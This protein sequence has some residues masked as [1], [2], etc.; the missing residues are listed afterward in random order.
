MGQLNRSNDVQTKPDQAASLFGPS[1]RP[2]AFWSRLVSTSWYQ[3]NLHKCARR[4][5]RR[6]NSPPQWLDDLKHDAMLLL[7]R[8]LAHAHDGSTAASHT[9]SRACLFAA[10]LGHCREALK[11][12]RWA[13]RHAR[14]FHDE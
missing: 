13:N 10:T 1:I 14:Q 7:A 3:E 5:L 12:M 2:P 11:R 4:A 6:S 8:Q 9:K